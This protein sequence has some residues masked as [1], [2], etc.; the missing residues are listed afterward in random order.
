SFF[1]EFHCRKYLFSLLKKD[2]I[3][4]KKYAIVIHFMD[5][6]LGLFCSNNKSQKINFRYRM[7]LKFWLK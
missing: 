2:K 7:K 1:E 3:R 5:I 6:L 4:F